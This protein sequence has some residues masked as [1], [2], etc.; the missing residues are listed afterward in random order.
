MPYFGNSVSSVFRRLLPSVV[1]SLA[2]DVGDSMAKSLSHA[3]T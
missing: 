1:V 2:G 3:C